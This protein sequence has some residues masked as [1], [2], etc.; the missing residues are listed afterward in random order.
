MHPFV[1]LG[2]VEISTFGVFSA[3][4]FIVGLFVFW[5]TARRQEANEEALLDLALLSSLGG[6]LLARVWYIFGHGKF[7]GVLDW[8][9]IFS[10]PG[11]DWQGFLIGFF[12]SAYKFCQWKKWSFLKMADLVALVFPLTQAIGSLGCALNGCLAG[13]VTNLPWGVMVIGY[14]G[15]RHPLALYHFFAASLLFLFLLRLRK[16]VRLPGQIFWWFGLGEGLTQFLLTRWRQGRMIYW[17]RLP[18]PQLIWIGITLSSFI[19]LSRR[20]RR[21]RW[22][23]EDWRRQIG[24]VWTRLTG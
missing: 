18:V 8:F 11:L 3:I 20:A 1:N 9:N 22:Q 23:K 4:A 17:G 24:R 2:P 6:L 15:K 21:R 5:L 12:L 14:A 19:I 10:R 16:Q 13:R 7:F